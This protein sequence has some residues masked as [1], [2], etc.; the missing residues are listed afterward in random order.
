M[1]NFTIYADELPKFTF[2]HGVVKQEKE[3]FI[4]PY[5]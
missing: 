4:Q 1:V 2:I 5:E 3:V